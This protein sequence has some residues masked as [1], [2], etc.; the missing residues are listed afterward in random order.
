[1]RAEPR[2]SL[3]AQVLRRIVQPVF[4][5]CRL[6]SI[7]PLCDGLRNANFK[8][9]L[10][11]AAEPVALR[12]YEHDV[13]LCQ[14]EVDLMRLVDGSVPAPEV[15][16]AEPNGWDD[17]PPFILTRWIEGITFRDLKRTGDAQAIGE[18]AQA[19]GEAL[20][21]IGRFTFP[22]PGWLMPGPAVGPPLAEGADA[23]PRFVDLCLAADNLRLR[24][25]APLRDRTQTMMWSWAPQLRGIEEHASLVH[26]DFNRRNLLVRMARGR[27]SVAA[28]L[29]WEFA[30]SGSPLGDLG[31]FLRYE[32]IARPIAEP[33]FSAGYERAGG[34]LPHEWRRL[35]RLLNLVAVCESLT[36][37]EL[38]ETVAAELVELVRATIQDRDP[39]FG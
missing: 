10:D 9:R 3:P 35:A 34:C 16:H 18:A 14:K 32:R 24:M 2:R 39:H 15:I 22:K 7:E 25:P 31:N 17:L 13:S 36:H 11:P 30:V 27:W 4:P 8:L 23:L 26:G 33:H 37:D 20:A 6:L 19:V 38:P 28:V 21:A 1:M 29:D 5:G 12:I